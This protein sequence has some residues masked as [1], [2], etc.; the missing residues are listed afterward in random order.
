MAN[1]DYC[2][3]IHNQRLD[4]LVNYLN[5]IKQHYNKQIV[6]ENKQLIKDVKKKCKEASKILDEILDLDK[7]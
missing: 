3:N 4:S 2:L 1:N 6:K 7:N 5:G